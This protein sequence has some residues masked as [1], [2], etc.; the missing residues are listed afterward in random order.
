MRLEGFEPSKSLV[1]SRF[2]HVSVQEHDTVR[3]GDPILR[4]QYQNNKGAGAYVEVHSKKEW[5][6]LLRLNGVLQPGGVPIKV[7]PWEPV[8]KLNGVLQPGGV[9][10]KLAPRRDYPRTTLVSKVDSTSG[11]E[12]ESAK[13][14]KAELA[15]ETATLE[16]KEQKSETAI[17]LAK[18]LGNVMDK[19]IVEAPKAAA[20]YEREEA[21]ALCLEK[22]LAIE[23]IEAEGAAEPATHEMKEP[24]SETPCLAKQLGN[25]SDKLIV[26][27]PK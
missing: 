3:P 13:Q 17:C 12:T 8:L 10:I 18:K 16:S 7:V 4:C 19:L 20:R 23:R 25:G 11:K 24:N 27:A 22:Q 5:K 15:A 21:E 2:G 26:E 9:Q 1:G 14:I 6:N